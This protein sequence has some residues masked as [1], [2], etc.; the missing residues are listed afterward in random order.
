MA[1]QEELA[2]QFAEGE[3]IAE[4][5]QQ[6]LAAQFEAGTPLPLSAPATPAV[7]HGP[8]PLVARPVASHAQPGL[9]EAADVRNESDQELLGKYAEWVASRPQEVTPE[10]QGRILRVSTA[11]RE[12]G[13][14]VTPDFKFIAD[15]LDQFERNLVGVE[16]GR[17]ARRHPKLLQYGLHPDVRPLLID[18]ATSLSF[19]AKA[20]GD[21]R[22]ARPIDE[23]GFWLPI[24]GPN[25]ARLA[26]APA[27]WR[28]GSEATTKANGLLFKSV[29]AL[30]LWWPTAVKDADALLGY[31]LGTREEGRAFVQSEIDRIDALPAR[32]HGLGAG[33]EVV[34][35][36]ISMAPMLA[37]DVA[38]RVTGGAAGAAI[39]GYVGAG[40][41]TLLGGPFGAAA[42]AAFGE[43]VGAA[44]GQ[45]LGSFSFNTMLAVGDL[46]ERIAQIP[47]PDGQP[48][49]L[50]RARP[51]A[52]FAA[53]AEGMV[54]ATGLGRVVHE[55]PGAGVVFRDAERQAIA[56]AFARTNL[57]G[58]AKQLAWRWGGAVAAARCCSSPN[59]DRRSRKRHSSV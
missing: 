19:M 35:R 9:W 15:N 28:A 24:F 48:L 21:W 55:L 52:W 6:E 4:P 32:A 38:S 40:I 58:I 10:Q 22:W 44:G 11:L 43:A 49:G 37:G 12:W 14:A 54:F 26:H 33:T 17:L 51:Y 46:Q 45:W 3:P 13:G 50:E 8:P 59:P 27:W 1:T 5:S 30:D 47:G 42:G 31:R 41:G 53:E 57:G 36:L 34:D 56:E 25:K 16:W 18:D 39:G 7:S 20:L 23:D 2:R 29:R